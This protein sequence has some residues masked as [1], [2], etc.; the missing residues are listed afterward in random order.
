MA[1]QEADP[2]VDLSRAERFGTL[3]A[4]VPADDHIEMVDTRAP[5]N[6]PAPAGSEESQL[7]LRDFT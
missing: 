7:A 6:R 4:R 2:E 1:E 3:P 5:Q